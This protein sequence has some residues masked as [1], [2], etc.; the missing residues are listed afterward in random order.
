MIQVHGDFFTRSVRS[1]Q[2]LTYEQGN[3]MKTQLKIEW[4]KLV[5]TDIDGLNEMV[6]ELTYEEWANT[7]SLPP[8]DIRYEP[9]GVDGD[10]IVFNVD[11]SLDD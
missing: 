1:F 3:R 7:D 4:W 8:M 11:Y 9:I 10:K 6:D 5:E 2:T